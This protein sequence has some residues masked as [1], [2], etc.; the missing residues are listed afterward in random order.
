LLA[1]LVKEL[2]ISGIIWSDPQLK[3]DYS[4]HLGVKKNTTK[5]SMYTLKCKKKVVL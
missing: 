5:I 2:A 1:L 4:A 3:S